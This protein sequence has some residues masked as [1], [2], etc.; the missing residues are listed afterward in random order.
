MNA[1]N[2]QKGT[3]HIARPAIGCVAAAV[4]IISSAF[5]VAAAIDIVSGAEKMKGAIIAGSFFLVCGLGGAFV[6]KAM[7]T[8][9]KRN[10]AAVE[11][12]V[13][14]LAA[15]NDAKLTA[16]ELAMRSELDLDAARLMLGE[17][18]TKRA[19]EILVDENGAEVYHFVELGQK[20]LS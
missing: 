6:A 19:A 12:M 11:S 5:V 20:Q 4:A 2:K 14:Q 8:A 17:M 15:Q 3:A 7:F 9:P 13:L 10:A 1:Q 16:S 18:V